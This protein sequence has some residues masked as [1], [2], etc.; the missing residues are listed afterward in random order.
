MFLQYRAV[1]TCFTAS[2]LYMFQFVSHSALVN[3]GRIQNMDHVCGPS[4]WTSS[5]TRSMD[6]PRG[7]PLIFE[8]EFLP[9]V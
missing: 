3:D 7:P 1:R 2:L 6:Y 9:E 8:G 5:W 4:P